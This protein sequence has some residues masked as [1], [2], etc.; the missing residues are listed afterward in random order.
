[1]KRLLI[2]L[3]FISFYGNSQQLKSFTEK[4]LG[5]EIC[6]S[7]TMNFSS[8]TEADDAIKKILSTIGASNRFVVQ[9]CDNISNAGAITISGIRY[10]FY[11]KKFMNKLNSY[12][13]YWSNMSI[14]AHEVGHHIN[15][16]TVDVLIS[17][18]KRKPKSLSESREMELEADK[19]SG[20]VL[21]KLGATLIQASEGIA[22]ISSNDDDTYSTHPSKSKRLA[23]IKQGYDNAY[24]NLASYKKNPSARAQEYFYSGIK[25]YRRGDLYGAISDY[26]IS[27]ESN[28]INDPNTFFNRGVAKSD[29]NDNNGAINDLTKAIEYNF[30]D[31]VQVYMLRG[32][33]YSLLKNNYDAIYDFTS[34]IKID[35]NNSNAYI[36]RGVSKISIGDKNGG[37]NDL[38]MATNMG[39]K[40]AATFISECY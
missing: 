18:D 3:F 25:K 11:N 27:I 32:I 13:D 7:F 15:Q 40:N 1:M 10:I 39:N 21:A 26:S 33:L 9:S 6:E 38:I 5:K 4:D 37:C 12:T 24:S 14:L 34:V 22:L 30:K 36:S 20:F 19:F 2:F 23:A 17:K 29:L 16:H 8:E 31:I 28:P 35:P